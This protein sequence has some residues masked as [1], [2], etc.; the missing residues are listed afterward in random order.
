MI[1]V[2][3]CTVVSTSGR[4]LSSAFSTSDCGWLGSTVTV[5][6]PDP[7]ILIFVNGSTCRDSVLA[8]PEPFT[9]E[10]I[11]QPVTPTQPKLS[12]MTITAM[13]VER[14]GRD[15]IMG[16]LLRVHQGRDMVLHS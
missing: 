10:P 5:T 4:M 8:T 6:L 7:S 3:P 2:S 13:K 9:L 11:E 1:S 15:E 12:D 16:A 14:I